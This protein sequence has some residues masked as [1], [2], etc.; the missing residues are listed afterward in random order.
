M[1]TVHC[2][3]S[4]WFATWLHLWGVVAAPS[5]VG[6][7]T[8]KLH[9]QLFRQ[10]QFK[11]RLRY[12]SLQCTSGLISSTSVLQLEGQSHHQTMT[13]WKSIQNNS[14]VLELGR[15]VSGHSQWH[16]RER[17]T[18]RRGRPGVGMEHSGSQGP[19][20][21]KYYGLWLFSTTQTENT[22]TI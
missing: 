8:T 16:K 14:P 4:N 3:Y 20:V 17:G 12:L 13:Q 15:Q 7:S 1:L 5:L 2:K 11:F 6:L 10:L 22:H 9:S 19:C 18:R 21:L